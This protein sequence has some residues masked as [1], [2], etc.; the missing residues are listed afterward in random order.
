MRNF[1]EMECTSSCRR[2]RAEMGCPLQ[3][4]GPYTTVELN[5]GTDKAFEAALAVDQSKLKEETLWYW[6]VV[7]GNTPCYVRL[8]ARA[9]LAN[10][11]E[12]ALISSFLTR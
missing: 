11:D 3:L 4:C 8:R 5:Y 10:L 12:S 1:L 7:G 9:S 2:F 6:R